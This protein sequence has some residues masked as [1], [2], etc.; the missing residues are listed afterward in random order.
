MKKVKRSLLALSVA[1]CILSS[2]ALAVT[3]PKET[4]IE[5]QDITVCYSTSS[6]DPG[7]PDGW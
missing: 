3:A 7:D 1:T 6:T 4:K 2:N 5:K